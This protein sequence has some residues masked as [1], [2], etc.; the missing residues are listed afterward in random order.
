MLFLNLKPRWPG[1]GSAGGGASYTELQ[2][3]EGCVYIAEA[4]A[5][6]EMHAQWRGR[7]LV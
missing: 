2:P 3:V 5:Q 4:W 7:E 1:V 6:L